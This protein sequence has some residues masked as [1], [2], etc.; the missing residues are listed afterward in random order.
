MILLM[1]TAPPKKAPWYHGRGLPPLGLAYIAASLEKAGF[2]VEIL[3]NYLLNKPLEEI[4]V[5]FSGL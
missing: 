2:E 3:D 1:T 5:H 4:L